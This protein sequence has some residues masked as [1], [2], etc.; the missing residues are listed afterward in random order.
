MDINEDE[1]VVIE[2]LGLSRS[3][4]GGWMVVTLVS[5]PILS[6]V[7]AFPILSY[8]MLSESQYQRTPTTISLPGLC[9]PIY[10]CR[11]WHGGVWRGM[12]GVCVCV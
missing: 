3:G 7:M 5:Y 8:P 6:Y 10:D 2:C 9:I 11:I 1:S 4:R 12:A